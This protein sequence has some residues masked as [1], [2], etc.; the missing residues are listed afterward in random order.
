[1]VTDWKISMDLIIGLSRWLFSDDC[2][3]I[4]SWK[5]NFKSLRRKESHHFI[6]G[7]VLGAVVGVAAKLVMVAPSI[8][9]F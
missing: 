6:A 3:R 5:V 1:M 4:K 7:L 8:D 9:C 2:C